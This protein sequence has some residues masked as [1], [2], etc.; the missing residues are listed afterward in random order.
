MGWKSGKREIIKPA[1]GEPKVLDADGVDGVVGTTL[2]LDISGVQHKASRRDARTVVLSGTSAE[3]ERYVAD[4]LESVAAL[5]AQ[6]VPIFD[7]A[8][9]PPKL[10][11]QT[12]R[13]TDQKSFAKQARE[14]EDAGNKTRAAQLWKKAAA[15]KEDMVSAVMS[16]CRRR[17]IGYLVAP[18]EADAQLVAAQ[19]DGLGSVVLVCSDDSDLV[20]Y[21]ATDCIYEYDPIN[22]TGLRVRLFDDILGKVTD[23]IGTLGPPSPLPGSCPYMEGGERVLIRRLELRP[24]VGVLHPL[25]VRFH[26]EHPELGNQARPRRHDAHGLARRAHPPRPTPRAARSPGRV[27]G[28][29]LVVRVHEDGALRGVQDG[30]R[31]GGSRSQGRLRV[32][33][34][35]A[36]PRVQGDLGGARPDLAG[37]DR[38]RG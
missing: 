7:G 11:T 38:R 17:K 32:L 10:A 20:A 14:A 28:D 13:R 37:P 26:G 22:R 24:L 12:A 15:P 21:A 3:A 4:Y 30:G 36:P 6:A 27:V 19:Q 16:H 35:P 18:Y 2:L 8:P 34:L 23:P 31:A 25:L 1:A 9:Y 29:D 33:G 5:G